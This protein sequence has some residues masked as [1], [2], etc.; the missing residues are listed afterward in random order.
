MFYERFKSQSDLD[1]HLAM[2]HFK[3]FVAFRQTA[4]QDPVASIVISTWRSI[5]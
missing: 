5:A 1:Y 2:P 3:N 4:S